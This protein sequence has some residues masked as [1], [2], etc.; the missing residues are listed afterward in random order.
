MTVT[1]KIRITSYNVCYTKLLRVKTQVS[2][3]EWRIRQDLACL[4]RLVAHHGW[5][6]LLFT[7]LSARVPG[8]EHHFLLNPVGMLFEEVTA[9]SLVKVDAEG[10]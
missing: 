3:D 8:A 6:D 10:T 7:H 4:Y 1:A 9:S 2:A 5:D